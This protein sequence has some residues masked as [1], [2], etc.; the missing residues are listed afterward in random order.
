MS[1][2]FFFRELFHHHFIKR[3]QLSVKV[4]GFFIFRPLVTICKMYPQVLSLCEQ[5][6]PSITILGTFF[7][8]KAAIRGSGSNLIKRSASY[9]GLQWKNVLGTDVLLLEIGPSSHPGVPCWQERNAG[10]LPLLSEC[11]SP[12]LGNRVLSDSEERDSGTRSLGP[13]PGSPPPPNTQA[14]PCAGPEPTPT[15]GFCSFPLS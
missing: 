9:P 8:I 4:G 1:K 11:N 5:I 2:C 14:P 7:L 6:G 12:A 13:S 10:T 15:E 3:N